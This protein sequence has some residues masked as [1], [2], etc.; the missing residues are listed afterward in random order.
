[1]N[2]DVTLVTVPIE[3]Q[4][5]EQAL[6]LKL[7]PSVPLAILI[8]NQGHLGLLSIFVPYMPQIV[9]DC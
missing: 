5:D 2:A 8:Q 1:M 6:W 7:P 3:T 4:P 9:V